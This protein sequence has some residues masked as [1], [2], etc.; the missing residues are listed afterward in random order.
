MEDPHP[1]P[2]NAGMRSGTQIPGHST[3]HR[4]LWS[5]ILVLVAALGLIVFFA[6]RAP[7]GRDSRTSSP[8]PGAGSRAGSPASLATATS[9]PV[10]PRVGALAPEFT[11]NDVYTDGEI[12]LS[13]LRGHPVWINF[14][15]T[16]CAPCLEE[17]PDIQAV[18]DQY[19]GQGLRLLGLNQADGTQKIKA[20]AEGRHYTWTFAVD[21]DDAVYHQYGIPGLPAHV[22]IDKN[23]VIRTLTFGELTPH[24]M[25]EGIKS[26]SG[27]SGATN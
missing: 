26:I 24:Q 25:E 27:D 20:F 2:D 21:W 4:A 3:V 6:S 9:L 18:Y 15:A 19:K 14:W 5:L 16:W 7:A 22:F 12:T 8:T 23:G 11:F 17:M 13:S 10:A 1:E